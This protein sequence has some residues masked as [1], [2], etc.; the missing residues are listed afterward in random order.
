MA[1]WRQAV[2]GVT[3]HGPGMPWD[4]TM[5]NFVALV[6]SPFRLGLCLINKDSLPIRNVESLEFEF[7]DDIYKER[8]AHEYLP[9][10]DFR[11]ADQFAQ[12]RVVGGRVI[13]AIE[14]K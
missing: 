3:H 8:R 11:L 4:D 10:C 7:P 2:L 12:R 9:P 1:L 14:F 13:L 5:D 6:P